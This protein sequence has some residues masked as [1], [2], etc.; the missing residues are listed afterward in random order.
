MHFNE[1]YYHSSS[2]SKRELGANKNFKKVQQKVKD[3]KLWNSDSRM[4]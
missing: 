1:L 4:I 2:S 3:T